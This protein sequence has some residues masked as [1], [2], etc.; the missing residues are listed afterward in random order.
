MASPTDPL[1]DEE[2]ERCRYH[3]GYP[4]MQAAASIQYGIPRP[5]QTA[6]LAEASFNLV[7]PLARPRVRKLLEILDGLECRILGA[8]DVLEA[9]K[10]G[11]LETRENAPDLIERQYHRFACRL[12]DVLGVPL[13]PFADRNKRGSAVMAGS[14]PVRR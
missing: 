13:Y 12:A 5:I 2:K 6:F 3:L 9:S 10:L 4:E 7:L 8:T 11:N 1:T 14:I